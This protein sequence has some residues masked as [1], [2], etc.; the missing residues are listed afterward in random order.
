[1]ALGFRDL[2]AWLF[3]WKSVGVVYP[4]AAGQ[5][6]T[7]GLRAGQIDT[8]TAAAARVDTP[9]SLTGQIHG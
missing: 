1:M 6:V 8:A 7:A 4:P 5:V 9:G 3:G 2:L